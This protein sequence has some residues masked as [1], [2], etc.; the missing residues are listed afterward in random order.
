MLLRRVSLFYLI[1]IGCFG[2]AAGQTDEAKSAKD[3]LKRQSVLVEQILSEIP[4]LKLSENRAVVFAKTGSLIWETDSKRARE[5]FQNAFLELINAQIRAENER[6]NPNTQNELLNGLVTRPQ[7]FQIVAA[8]DAAL[9]LE[10][11]PKTRPANLLKSLTVQPRKS[12]KIGGG[13]SNYGNLAQ[14]ELN[15][16]QTLTRL[17]ADQNPAQ[18]A[19]LLKDSIKKGITDETLNL[20]K[21]LAEKDRTAA[22]DLSTDITGKLLQT[23]YTT[24]NP[25]YYQNLNITAAF[26]NEYAAN[27]QKTGTN[28]NLDAVQMNNLATKYFDF[29]LSQ[30]KNNRNGFYYNYQ[31]VQLAEKLAPNLVGQLKAFQNDNA[32]ERG[33]ESNVLSSPEIKEDLPP[34]QMVEAAKK[35]PLANRPSVYLA[36][37]N[38][39][40]SQGN[41]SRARE[42]LDDNF[43]D[44]ALENAVQSMNWYYAHQ[45][46]NEGKFAEAENLLDSFPESNRI[47]A[48]IN[49]AKVVYQKNPAENKAYA[50]AILGKV[51]A[52]ISD[53]PESSNELSVL[54]QVIKGYSMIEPN[55]AFR[56]FE[57]LIPQM[58][59][60]SDAA[61]IINNFQGN[62]NVRNGEFLLTQGGSFGFYGIDYSILRI[63]AGQDFDRTVSLLNNFNRS[64]VRINFK[65]L[66]AEGLSR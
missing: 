65:L 3:K 19:D 13:N 44:D 36:A 48:F 49:L 33:F 39:F 53:K 14:T 16:E 61:A 34:E 54:M 11:L 57:L 8:R 5:L 60:L 58:N 12:A 42:I 31:I 10:F 18:A 21:K 30:I 22:A 29:Y 46:M 64:E 23:K 59:E 51:R 56:L 17:A 50:G 1:L 25:S 40:V 45:L 26:L 6:K 32:R 7:I 38:K 63:F 52:L 62:G 15:L 27:R 9:A 47:S 28:L 43:E 4:N 55:E 37:A 2:S 35:V 20:L 24:D 41:I 66:A